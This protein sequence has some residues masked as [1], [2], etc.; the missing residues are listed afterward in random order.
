MV[1]LKLNDSRIRSIVKTL[2]WRVTGS[3]ATFLIAWIIGGDLAVAGTIAVIQIIANTILYYCHE[4]VWN[5]ISWGRINT[6]TKE[7]DA[8]NLQKIS[9]STK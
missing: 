6:A 1:L 8:C 4:R 9:A 7:I 3:F 5:L 2:T